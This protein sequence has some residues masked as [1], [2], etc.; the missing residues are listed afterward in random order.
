METKKRS[1][2]EAHA[3]L[4]AMVDQVMFVSKDFEILHANKALLDA[5]GLG[6]EDV[7]G[8]HCYKVTHHRKTPCDSSKHPC[9]LSE[10]MKGKPCTATHTHYDKDGKEF[11]VKVIARPWRKKGEVVGFIHV[12]KNI[13][14]LERG[15][16]TRAATREKAAISGFAR[17]GLVTTDLEGNITSVNKA[18]EEFLAEAGIDV[19]KFVGKSA[20]RLLNKYAEI[21]E[22]T[23]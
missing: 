17:D 13:A 20:H 6:M 23:A 14:E 10:A 18:M 3:I 22:E 8:K 21:I 12:A 11:R 2:A 5:V 1:V 9:P 7:I 16:L 4:D 15:G 19:K